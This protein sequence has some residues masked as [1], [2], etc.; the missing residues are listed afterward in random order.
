MTDARPADLRPLDPRRVY[1]DHLKA[2][3][4]AAGT[5]FYR[6]LYLDYFLAYLAGRNI[7]DVR[8]VTPAVITD[9]RRHATRC[10]NRKT[11]KPL[12]G[13]TVGER[14]S[15]VKVFYA[16]LAGR[17][18]VLLDPTRGLEESRR[19]DRLPRTILTE[20]E[21]AGI[22]AQAKP[23]R[24]W[25]LRDRAILELLY[26]TA[27]RRR[28]LRN[29]NIGDVDLGQGVVWV[30][31]GKGGKDRVVPLGRTARRWVEAYLKRRPE[32]FRPMPRS[33][34]KR[35]PNPLETYRR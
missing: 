26:S 13:K 11:G 27:L 16:H 8:D 24:L 23:T 34:V 20:G 6:A 3:G 29:L 30:R 4:Q 28:E 14:L 2:K 12:A 10:P 25:G 17:G 32:L 9:Y 31:K 35:K 15:V 33:R 19:C 21:I 7:R 22:I 5:R 18:D 1:L